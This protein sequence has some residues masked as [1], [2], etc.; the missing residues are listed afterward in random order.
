VVA[1]FH[2]GGWVV[3]SIESVDTT[4]R[5][6]ANASG[7][8]VVS[9]GYRLA[10]E[11]PFRPG[12]RTA[13]RR[14]SA[15]S[16]IRR[17][18]A[19]PATAREATSRSP[20]A[21]RLRDDVR[22]QALIYPVADAGLNTPSMRDFGEATASPSP[23]AALLEPLRRRAD[24]F[25]ARHLAA[26]RRRPRGAAAHFVLTAEFDI[27]RD[28]GEAFVK[29]LEK[30]GVDVTHRRFDGTIPRVLAPGWR[31]RRRRARRSTRSAP[32]RRPAHRS[33]TRPV[34]TS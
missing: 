24:G 10:P 23:A 25:Q 33:L 9:V 13:S 27:L 7:A 19:W 2:G 29:K 16:G 20:V 1:Y 31:R 15:A 30:A 18:A 28:E 4:C 17:A 8:I 26:A 3:G 11:H 5:A 34:A 22:A 12:S 14:P 21:R 6:L 32:A